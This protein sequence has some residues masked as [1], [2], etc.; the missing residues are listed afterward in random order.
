MR[1]T[2][3]HTTRYRYETPLANAMQQLR[4]TPEDG[5]SQRVVEWS[6]EAPGIERATT[7]KDAF[8]KRSEEEVVEAARNVQTGVPIA[9]PVFD[10]AREEDI[11][12][13]LSEAG[14]LLTADSTASGGTSACSHSP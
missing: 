8:G 3:R 1:L 2:V 7:Y 4:L 9:T 6:I 13:A 14:L 11:V 10:G 5:P 12:H